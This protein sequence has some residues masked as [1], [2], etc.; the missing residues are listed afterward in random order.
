MIQRLICA[1]CPAMIV[2]DE[3][4]RRITIL[5][6]SGKPDKKIE[7]SIIRAN[8][9]TGTKER[10]DSPTASTPWADRHIRAD[11]EQEKLIAIR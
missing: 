3:H 11:E 2:I 4:V 10:I 8:P 5:I 6:F 9:G 1:G 7:V